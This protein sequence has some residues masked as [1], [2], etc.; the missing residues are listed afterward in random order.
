MDFLQI[1]QVSSNYLF[2]KN[3]FLF[4]FSGFRVDWTVP[5]YL[6]TAGARSNISKAQRTTTMD[7]GLIFLFPGD[8]LAKPP[9]RNGILGF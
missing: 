9:G 2:T 7:G 8:S 5:Q 4:Y 1:K 6:I 3:P